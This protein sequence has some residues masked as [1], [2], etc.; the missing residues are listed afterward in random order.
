V[1]G[2]VPPALAVENVGGFFASVPAWGLFAVVGLV[3]GVGLAMLIA[4]GRRGPGKPAEPESAPTM[5]E[6]EPSE[7]ATEAEAAP[8]ETPAEYIEDLGGEQ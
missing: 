5:A 1:A 8:P 3:V 7:A 4:R 2:F 6:E